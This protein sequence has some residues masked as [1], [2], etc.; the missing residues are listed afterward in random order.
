MV[1]LGG[2]CGLLHLLHLGHRSGRRGGLQLQREEHH[3]PP[4][5]RNHYAITLAGVAVVAVFLP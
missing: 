2:V 4:D 5:R 3:G 1:L